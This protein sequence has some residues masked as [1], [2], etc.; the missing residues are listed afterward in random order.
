VTNI[1]FASTHAT[2][3]VYLLSEGYN[4]P[5]TIAVITANCRHPIIPPASDVILEKKYSDP[6]CIIMSCVL[7]MIVHYICM[8]I[9]Y[10]V[11]LSQVT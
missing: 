7:P 5:I 10:A 6:L 4:I 11:Y 8:Y 3:E 1:N 2:E 9:R